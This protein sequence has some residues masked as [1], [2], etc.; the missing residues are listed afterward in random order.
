MLMTIWHSGST[1]KSMGR[2][3]TITNL[4]LGERPQSTT[5]HIAADI[6]R[7]SATEQQ[8]NRTGVSAQVSVT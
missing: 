7:S 8:N 1:A 4:A 6:D 3:A 5:M 2:A